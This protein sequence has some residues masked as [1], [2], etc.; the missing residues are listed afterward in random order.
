MLFIVRNKNFYY[1]YVANLPKKGETI[2]GHAFQTGFGGKGANQIIAASKM[3]SKTAFIGKLGGDTWATSYLENF[4][5][6][7]VNIDFLEM[8]ENQV[9]FPISS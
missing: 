6:N 3:N 8:V 7:N 5:N 1:S 4:K 9:D 2:H